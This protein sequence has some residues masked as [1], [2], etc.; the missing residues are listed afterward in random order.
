LRQYPSLCAEEPSEQALVKETQPGE[1]GLAEVKQSSNAAYAFGAFRLVPKERKLLLAN[2]PVHIGSRAFAILVALVERAGTI[3]SG[4]ELMRLVWPGIT[5]DEANLR[6]QLGSLRKALA[7]GEGGRHAVE[8]VPLRGYCFVLP[9]VQSAGPAAPAGIELEH[10]LPTL[11]TPTVGRGDAIELL[12]KSL[13]SHRLVTI[14]GPGGIGKT[15]IAVAVA[16][17]SLA[18]FADGAR[19]VDFSSLAEPRLVAS[20]LASAAR[21]LCTFPGSACGPGRSPAR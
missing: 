1:V 9:V 21:H 19:F 6:V 20:A 3:V 5:V 8:T 2:E 7:R 17:R 18:L 15:T 12:A 4:D 13:A 16:R 10:N 11:L 14:I